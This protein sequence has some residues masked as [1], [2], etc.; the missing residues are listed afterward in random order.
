MDARHRRQAHQVVHRVDTGFL[1]QAVDHQPVTR[2][3]DVVPAL[4][5]AFEMQAGG[6]N[7]AE[8][9]LQRRERDRRAGHAGQ[10]GA[11]AAAQARFELRRGT[12][13][14][15]GDRTA[16]R[17]AVFGQRQDGRIAIGGP[18]NGRPGHG[19]TGAG[20]G[21]A[22]EVAT[23]GRHFPY[24]L[25]RQ[26]AFRCALDAPGA[27]GD[28]G[29]AYSCSDASSSDLPT[30]FSDALLG[31]CGMFSELPEAI[32]MQTVRQIDGKFGSMSL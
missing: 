26:E 32:W 9:A 3:I 10:P 14:T 20:E 13:R 11:F 12:V 7:D 2:R 18:C 15:F 24:L 1:H 19:H 16:Q 17:G 30:F 23:S 4:V 21:S 8:Q 28:L 5:V 31:R 27:W 25:R 6:R 22:Q 29:H